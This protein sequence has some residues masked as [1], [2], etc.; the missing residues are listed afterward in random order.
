MSSGKPVPVSASTAVG[1]F[2][3]LHNTSDKVLFFKHACYALTEPLAKVAFTSLC[4]VI[5]RLSEHYCIALQSFPVVS[6]GRTAQGIGLGIPF[7]ETKVS[8]VEE[9]FP[10]FLSA[11]ANDT[12]FAKVKAV[13]ACGGLRA[14][15]LAESPSFCE[16]TYG[17][18]NWIILTRQLWCF[19]W[20]RNAVRQI[21]DAD[22]EG[23]G[24]DDEK[25]KGSIGKI[26]L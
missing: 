25:L 16:K 15:A 4:R 26:S 12:M 17:S 20:E 7:R 2:L 18:N 10:T 14:G 11:Y 1:R 5:R 9:D 3:Q 13:V 22:N 8:I 19:G 6:L 23:N 21:I 24:Y